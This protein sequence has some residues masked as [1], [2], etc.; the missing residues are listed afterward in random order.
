MR[1]SIACAVLGLDVYPLQAQDAIPD[2]RGEWRSDTLSIV[3][4]STPYNPA[5]PGDTRPRVLEGEFTLT[6]EGQDGRRFWGTISGARAKEKFIGAL[7]RDNKTGIGSDED[8]TFLTNLI[9]PNALERCYTHT[10]HR[11]KTGDSMMA[12]CADYVRAPK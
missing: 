5:R 11:S 1:V 10:H 6:V 3:A 4:G 12:S 2:L 7:S 9:G 8:G